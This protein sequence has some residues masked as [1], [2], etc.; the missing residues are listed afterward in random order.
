M[1]FQIVDDAPP[2]IP[3]APEWWITDDTP[4]GGWVETLGPPSEPPGPLKPR[5]KG[6]PWLWVIPGVAV[7]VY[8]VYQWRSK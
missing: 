1:D 4:T 8:L 5:R 2:T 3:D 7:V 6:S